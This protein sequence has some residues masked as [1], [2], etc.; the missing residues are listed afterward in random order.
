MTSCLSASK[1]RIPTIQNK[2]ARWTQPAGDRD[3]CFVEARV[4]TRRIYG[5]IAADTAATT[6]YVAICELGSL[7][8]DCP[9]EPPSA[10]LD[11]IN[12]PWSGNALSGS[13][14]TRAFA[15]F[16]YCPLL[17][18]ESALITLRSF[19]DIIRRDIP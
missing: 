16:A 6:T 8:S 19:R 3:F 14:S 13:G 15:G 18:L 12:L 5:L 10:D 7:Q 4:F 1:L 9:V 11:D 17:P 2:S